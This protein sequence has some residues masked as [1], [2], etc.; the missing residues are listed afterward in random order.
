MRT[1]KI[2]GD[3]ERLPS[4]VGASRVRKRRRWC[5][6]VGVSLVVVAYLDS[7]LPAPVA[8]EVAGRMKPL[9]PL[10][11]RDFVDSLGVEVGVT[12]ALFAVLLSMEDRVRRVMHEAFAVSSVQVRQQLE[13]LPHAGGEAVEADDALLAVGDLVQRC[14]LSQVGVPTVPTV[15]TEVA[16]SDGGRLRY[17]FLANRRPR[18]E[19]CLWSRDRTTDGGRHRVELRHD[20]HVGGQP[21]LGCATEWLEP[22][23]FLVEARD[24]VQELAM[25]LRERSSRR[26]RRR[27]PRYRG[28]GGRGYASRTVADEAAAM[29]PR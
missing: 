28:G 5:T 27:K 11:S 13:D 3:P 2:P 10:V 23:P 24:L 15:P 25:R 6:T 17:R 14:G 8:G 9:C 19:W 7:I 29:R 18:V 12:L 22:G 26:G 20:V 16:G 21:L 1:G 4:V